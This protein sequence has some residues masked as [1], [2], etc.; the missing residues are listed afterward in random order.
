[1]NIFGQLCD[2]SLV[3]LS[4]KRV[5]IFKEKT[6][7]PIEQN[8]ARNIFSRLNNEVPNE[9]S[10][11]ESNNELTINEYYKACLLYCKNQIFNLSYLDNKVMLYNTGFVHFRSISMIAET[12]K[13]LRIDLGYD[14][15]MVS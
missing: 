1:M 14:E 9:I 10:Q 5:S 7:L 3:S 15:K 12:L 6:N 13:V 11:L 2:F 8:I 4:R